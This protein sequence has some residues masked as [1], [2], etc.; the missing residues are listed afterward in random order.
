MWLA[1]VLTA[2]VSSAPTPVPTLDLQRYAGR[3]YEIARY[4]NRFQKQCARDT[5]AE[6]VL[7]AD[8]RITVTNRCVRADGS[9]DQAVGVARL[10]TPG[11]PASKLKVRFAP[12]FLSF[13]PQVWGD[14][15]VLALAPDYRYAVVGDP[16]RNYLWI[17]SRTAQMS[18][19]DYRAAVDAAAAQGFDTTRLQR[20]EQTPR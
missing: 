15:W 20:T 19:A 1:L 2:M 14:Y 6:Y 9:T 8:G 16:G 7:G 3:W 5:T 17:L 18:A 11:G 12:A 4:P 10:A 13:I